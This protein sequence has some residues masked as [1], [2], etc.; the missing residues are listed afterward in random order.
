MRPLFLEY[1]ADPR[2]AESGICETE[3]FNGPFFLIAPVLHP[4]K[5][6][7]EVYLPKGD[8]WYDFHTHLFYEGGRTIDCE[9]PL[10]VM[11]I[12][13]K[14]GAVVPMSPP[15]LVTDDSEEAE[16]IFSVYEAEKMSGLLYID[17]G[18]STKYRDKEYSLLLCEGHLKK[19]YNR[20]ST[21]VEESS[22]KKGTSEPKKGTSVAGK[23]K[24][25]CSR[26]RGDLEPVLSRH[27]FITF[28][29][30]FKN[31]VEKI[32]SVILDGRPLDELGD[33]KSGWKLSENSVQVVITEIDLP[34]TLDVYYL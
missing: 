11:P 16:I 13:I 34:F 26:I 8:N 29:I 32:E 23:I 25:Q 18:K 17:D 33:N 20:G 22:G 3:F 2:C 5:V 27:P 7:R 1:P 24:L 9:A 4:G 31:R 19:N 28:R 6:S 30:Y 14:A 15:A 12:F 21:N 10:E